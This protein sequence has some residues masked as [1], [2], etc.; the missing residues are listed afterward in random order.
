LQSGLDLFGCCDALP[1]LQFLSSQGSVDGVTRQNTLT[2]DGLA[3]E[4]GAQLCQQIYQLFQQHRA[5]AV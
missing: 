4:V 2:E 1:I 5:A 3:P